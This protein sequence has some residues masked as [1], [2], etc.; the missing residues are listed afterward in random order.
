[1]I[2]REHVLWTL[3]VPHTPISSLTMMSPW[4]KPCIISPTNQQFGISTAWCTGTMVVLGR[5]NVEQSHKS[6][7]N[8]DWTFFPWENTFQPTWP[9]FSCFVLCLYVHILSPKLGHHTW[10]LGSFFPGTY[11]VMSSSKHL[12]NIGLQYA[13]AW[14]G[15]RGVAKRCAVVVGGGR[16]IVGL[17]NH[18]GLHNVSTGW[19]EGN[20]KAALADNYLEMRVLQAYIWKW[21]IQPILQDCIYYKL[22]ANLVF[23]LQEGT[24][25]QFRWAET[26]WTQRRIRTTWSTRP[27]WAS[28]CNP[29]LL[30]RVWQKFHHQWGRRRDES[31]GWCC[32]TREDSCILWCVV[33]KD[34]GLLARRDT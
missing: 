6:L 5:C 8:K 13:S 16:K 22:F 33:Q 10:L 25:P 31:G 7:F 14:S 3:L 18:I 32:R 1:M 17:L 27:C 9:I 23:F 15:R 34:P 20:N 19:C 4:Y 30:S 24:Q 2:S 29:R 26:W 28:T 21:G 11:A 12:P